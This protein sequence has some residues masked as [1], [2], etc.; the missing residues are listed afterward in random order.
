MYQ[1]RSYITAKVIQK[2]TGIPM[3]TLHSMVSAGYLVPAV[4]ARGRGD[5]H[6]FEQTAIAQVERA[7]RVR[8]LMGDGSIAREILRALASNP[9]ETKFEYEDGD[10][11]ELVLA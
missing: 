1:A 10:K 7:V 11:L 4:R 8:Q 3:S 5:E 2:A 6:L 9:T